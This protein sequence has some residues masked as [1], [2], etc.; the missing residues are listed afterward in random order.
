MLIKLVV[1]EKKNLK[2][3]ENKM[4]IKKCSACGKDHENI[5]VENS[6][7]VCP[8]TGKKVLVKSLDNILKQQDENWKK[9]ENDLEI[10]SGNNKKKGI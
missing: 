7:C 5:I 1:K 6:F 8:E 3:K 2:R 9:L 4:N 10:R